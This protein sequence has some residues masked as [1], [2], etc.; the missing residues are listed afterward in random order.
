MVQHI[1]PQR[2]FTQTTRAAVDQNEE[3][4]PPNAEPLEDSRVEHLFDTL[5]L[6]EVVAS[7][8][9]A[10]CASE[11]RRLEILGYKNFADI[12]MPGMFEIEAQFRPAIE[13]DVRLNQIRLE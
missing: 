7:A 6:G 1:V 10:K 9:G 4:L 3:L 11:F 12:A 13:F 5:Q 8:E 2:L